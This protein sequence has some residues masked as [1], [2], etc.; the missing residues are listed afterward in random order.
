MTSVKVV[1]DSTADIPEDLVEE[2]DITVIP[3]NVNFG[4][5]ET[6]KD[7]EKL[8]PS[9]FYEKLQESDVMPTT[10]QPS[11]YDFE[12]LYSDLADSLEED[13]VIFSIHLS[14]QLSGTYQAA[15]IAAEE[16][17]SK[18][19]V[20]VID[21]KGASYS[22]GIIVTDIARLA[23]RGANRD[24]CRERLEQ[25]IQASSVYFIVDTLE[26]LQKNG[27]IGKASALVGSL[28]KMKPI[29]S[30]NK[31]GEVYPYEKIRGRKKAFERIV[32][33]LEET[34]GKQPVHVGVAHAVAP[35]AV[36]TIFTDIR[37]KLNVTSEVT[38]EIGA[39]IGSHVGPGTIA[40]IAA[41]AQES[42]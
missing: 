31:K 6:Y 1:T 13:T 21:S 4:E 38:T 26:Y 7:G 18:A 11:P 20:E 12:T 37:S 36:E 9:G 39:V 28:L 25:L 22:F 19:N 2:L 10:S 16:V 42:E 40:V 29:L 35:K 30:L 23:K 17:S 5:K 24:E 8:T 32:S 3:L 41:P 15:S 14:S 33:Q 27:R 34:Y